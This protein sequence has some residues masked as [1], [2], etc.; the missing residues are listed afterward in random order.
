ME[1]L[2]QL[3]LRELS[4]LPQLFQGHCFKGFLHPL[5]DPSTALRVHL[6]LKFLKV[7]G[8][9]DSHSIGLPRC[10]P[11]NLRVNLLEMLRVNF[12]SFWNELLVPV[13]IAGLI[14]SDQKHRSAPRIEGIEDAVWSPFMLA[15]Q[16]AHVGVLRTVNCIGMRSL[17]VNSLLFQK[18]RRKGD[19]LLFVRREAVP[20][21]FELVS[22]F[23]L[24]GR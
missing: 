4:S 18:S 14:A 8:H 13:R 2:S 12:V 11:V 19:A 6:C 9:F 10:V 15:S 16:F 17:K 24:V 22:E 23:N 1:H 5:F 3:V 20:P 7:S 21:R